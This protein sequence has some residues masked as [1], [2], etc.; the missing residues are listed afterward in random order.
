MWGAIKIM[1]CALL[2]LYLLS[3]AILAINV[4]PLIGG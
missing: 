2:G 3:L 4:V 1:V